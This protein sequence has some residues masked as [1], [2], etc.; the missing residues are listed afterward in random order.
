VVNKPK[1][2]NKKSSTKKKEEVMNSKNKQS[3][4]SAEKTVAFKISAPHAKKAVVTG[5]FRSWSDKGVN[6]SKNE[7]GLWTASVN[8]SPG[9]HEYM[10]IIDGTWMADPANPK[11]VSNPYGGANSV[12]VV[13]L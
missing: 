2:S 7:K 1:V 6:M 10:F 9:T 11:T 3:K 13:T 12:I 4:P 8:L 5:S